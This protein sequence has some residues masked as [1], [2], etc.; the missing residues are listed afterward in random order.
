MKWVAAVVAGFT[1][2]LGIIYFTNVFPAGNRSLHK[3]F[4]GIKTVTVE[5]GAYFQKVA[6]TKGEYLITSIFGKDKKD[7]DA[8]RSKDDDIT[9][10]E[11]DH[12][13]A[14]REKDRNNRNGQKTELKIGTG[15]E[16]KPLFNKPLENK[17]TN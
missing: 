7:K 14:E 10:S 17:L 8:D 16:T 9:S 2:M 11:S 3:A 15:Q 4:A 1:V 12:E 5:T 13:S 6:E